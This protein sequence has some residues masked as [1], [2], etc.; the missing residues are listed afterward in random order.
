MKSWIV[1]LFLNLFKIVINSKTKRKLSLSF[2]WVKIKFLSL[3]SESNALKSLKFFEHKI[4]FYSYKSLCYLLE[5]I[6]INHIY[7][8]ETDIKDPKI[9]DAGAN[10]GLAVVYFKMLYPKCHILSFEADPTTFEILN[11]NIM[12]ARFQNVETFNFALWNNEGFLDFYV[13][14][15]VAAG[16]NQG[17]FLQEGKALRVPTRKLSDYITTTVD[18]F[19]IDVEGAERYIFQDLIDNHKLYY[20]DQLCAE[21]HL[22]KSSVDDLIYIL[23]LLSSRFSIRIGTHTLF[24]QNYNLSQDC[25]IYAKKIKGN[26]LV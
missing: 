15:D 9:I 16:L 8:F 4:E 2:F 12:N 19:K 18:Y 25:M 22:I 21:V 7:Y 1:S 20:I 6:F 11:K 23:Q 24:N 13:N 3:R 17:F 10:I 14:A 26:S 5:E